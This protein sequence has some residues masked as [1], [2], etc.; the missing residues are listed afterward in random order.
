MNFLERFFSDDNLLFRLLGHMA[1]LLVLNLLWL[2]CS[3]PIITIGASTTAL[4]YC[5]L[6]IVEKEDAGLIAKFFRSFRM[7]LRQGIILTLLYATLSALLIADALISFRS[8]FMIGKLFLLLLPALL[9]ITIVSATYSYPLLARFDNTCPAI[10]RLSLFMGV[11][12]LPCTI[13]M[14]ALNLLVP[15]LLLAAPYL[16][17][18]SFPFWLLLGFAV[19]ALINSLMLARIFPAYAPT[20]DTQSSAS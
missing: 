9:V 10:L 17:W 11:R 5:T 12:H 15:A 7:N 1:D 16:F 14:V 6:K 2:L 20:A 19:I 3:L 18:Q 13:A 4:Y 8:D